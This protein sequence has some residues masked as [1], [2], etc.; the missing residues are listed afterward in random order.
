ME[1][2]MGAIKLISRIMKLCF[3]R[4]EVSWG[5]KGTANFNLIKRPS[6]ISLSGKSRVGFKMSYFSVDI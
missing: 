5:F 6:A 3:W 4:Y 2:K 1:E